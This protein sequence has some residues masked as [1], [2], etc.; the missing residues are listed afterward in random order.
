MK[1]M[2]KHQQSLGFA[3]ITSLLLLLL[4]SALAVGTMYMVVG[5]RSL[6]G[7][8]L[9]DTVAFY[10]AEAAME[11]MTVDVGNLYVARAA[12]LVSDITA[13]GCPT[14]SPC[15]SSYQPSIPGITYHTYTFTVPA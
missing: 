6:G 13:L 4:L 9:Q 11:K 14:S 5:E 7:N 3:L 2:R 10:G 15:A 8:D 1:I 12:P